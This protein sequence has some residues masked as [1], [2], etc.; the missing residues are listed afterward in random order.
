MF[1]VD[2]DFVEVDGTFSANI[3]SDGA[4]R[5]VCKVYATSGCVLG[6]PY[7]VA[8]AYTTSGNGWL[9]PHVLDASEKGLVGIASAAIASGCEGWI[10]VR[11]PVT[12]AQGAATSLTGSIGH[13][14]YWGGATGIGATGS[15]F[16]GLV[17]QIG[18]LAEYVNESTTANIFLTG[19]LFAQSL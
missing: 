11:G 15:A 13:A 17:H 16:Q 1:F 10:T 9:Q 4:G 7:R 14:V 3:K 8:Y 12:G 18:V 2:T 5:I 19:N 6:T